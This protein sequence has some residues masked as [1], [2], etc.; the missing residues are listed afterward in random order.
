MAITQTSSTTPTQDGLALLGRIF[1][2]ALFIPAGFGKIAGFAGT[3]GYIASVGLPLP[4]VGAA[5]AIVVE[6]GLGIL[7]LV[8][9]KTRLAALLIALFTL[10]AA[11]F[12]HNYWSMPADKVMINQLMFWK[13]IA[14]AGGL[15]AFTAFGPGRFSIDRK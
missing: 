3:A 14:I 6:L 4:Q 8:G 2:A 13:N 10:A 7:L 9:F 5:I 12:F 15:L 11:L 1:L